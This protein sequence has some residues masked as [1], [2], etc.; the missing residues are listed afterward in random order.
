MKRHLKSGMKLTE[1]KKYDK[2]S[3]F[4]TSLKLNPLLAKIKGQL[5]ILRMN[6]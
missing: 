6:G 4:K 3:Y 2:I 1:G 5:Q